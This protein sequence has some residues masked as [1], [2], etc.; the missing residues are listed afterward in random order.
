[1]TTKPSRGWR[2]AFKYKLAL[3]IAVIVAGVLAGTFFVLQNR[4]EARAIAGVRE[5][6][7]TT[8]Q[9]VI[10]LIEERSK[11]LTDLA[12]AAGG[13]ELVRTILTDP[14][15]DRR[16]N[17]DIVGSEIMPDYPQ[18]SLLSIVDHTGKIRGSS[19]Q[20]PDIEKI[21]VADSPLRA[22]LSGR[23]GHAF[24]RSGDRYH[25]VITLP[26][27]IGPPT[28]REV[29]GSIFVGMPWSAQDLR[30]IGAISRADIALLDNDAVVSSTGAAF[31]RSQPGQSGLSPAALRGISTTRPEIRRV[32]GRRYVFLT[33]EG[34]KATRAPTFVIAKSLDAQL[35]FVGDIRRVMIQFAILGIGVGLIVSLIMALNIARP[36]KTLTAV[37]R[38]IARDNYGTQVIVRTRD[39]FEQ[40]GEAFN[41]MIAGLR[42]RDLIR[43][44]FG[45]YVDREVAQRLLSRPESLHLGGQKREVVIL[46][47][48]IRGFSRLSE[49]ITPEATILLLNHYFSRMIA[50]IKQR[51]GIVVD[52]VGDGLMAFFDPLERQ[53]I[54]QTASTAL[55]CAFQMQ[56]EL[57]GVNARMAQD[58]LPSLAIGIGLN[59]GPAIVGNI[60]SMD[61]AKYGIVGA[62]VNLTQ[63]IQGEARPGEVVLSEPMFTLVSHAVEVRR[64]F[65]QV[66]KGFSDARNLFAVAPRQV[67]TPAV[68][69]NTS[70]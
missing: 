13:N 42:E 30:R 63:R 66:L 46:M 44:T 64:R 6:L 24:F 58:G 70:Q 25:Q 3:S 35:G 20:G 69:F 60:G 56:H 28:G 19:S 47:A 68:S 32:S 17:D 67:R 61:R 62:E 36:I 37:A 38:L 59:T 53:E 52:F 29:L 7:H 2:I 65:E 33:I 31:E 39:E 15:L 45:R 50:T 5:D 49:Q 16:T 26:L 54:S 51:D 8:R 57:T 55:N 9:L 4:I 14:T 41:Q 43:S 23:I 40:L 34:Q 1:M 48:D 12:L 21:L 27:L 10:D 11:R 22:G 18:L